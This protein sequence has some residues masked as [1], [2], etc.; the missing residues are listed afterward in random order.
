MA[1][2]NPVTENR[3]EPRPVSR[4]PY[5]AANF[6]AGQIVARGVEQVGEA[7]RE[8]A[9]A[10]HQ[11]NIQHAEAAA[12]QA[13]SEALVRVG[14]VRSQVETTSGLGAETR[15]QEGE[16]EIEQIGR[17]IEQSLGDP[18]ARRMFNDSFRSAT[19]SDRLRM[20]EHANRQIRVAEDAADEA[21]VDLS[22]TRMV[23]MRDDPAL[24]ARELQTMDAAIEHRF[25]GMPP[26][27][28]ELAKIRAHSNAHRATALAILSADE[29]GAGIEAMAYVREHA[30]EIVPEQELNLFQTIQPQLDNDVVS[31][32]LGETMATVARGETSAE[33]IAPDETSS[34][35][36]HEI[37]GTEYS[38][39]GDARRV[40]NQDVPAHQRRGRTAQDF[41]APQGTP[42]RPP[43]AGVVSSAPQT[44]QGANGYMIRVRHPN[45]LETTYLH[46]NGPSPLRE[47]DEVTA[48]TVLGG[49]GSTGHSTGPHVDFSVRN[50]STGAVVDPRSVT[51]SS[52]EL[53]LYQ[54][55]R[56]DLAAQYRAA[57]EVARRMGLNSR[58]YD[59]LLER[60]DRNAAREDRLEARRQ[61]ELDRQ[62]MVRIA[63]LD[64]NLTSISQVPS[65]GQLSPQ[66][67]M[68]IQDQ[69]RQ[70]TR[71]N[72][73]DANSDRYLDILDLAY[74]TT[75][76]QAAFMAINPRAE[77]V[78]RGE[79]AEIIR[80]QGAIRDSTERSLEDSRVAADY[81]RIDTAIRRS[82]TSGRPADINV[83]RGAGDTDRQRFNQL[84]EAV[85]IRVEREQR[86]KGG[87]LS[88]AEL[89]GAVNAEL[90][91]VTVRN[92]RGQP[93]G[94]A[95]QYRAGEIA[96]RAG[97]GGRMT[98]EVPM[99]D[100]RRI[101]SM[102]QDRGIPNP[103]Q[104]QIAYYYRRSLRGN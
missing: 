34:A 44:Q 48:Q 84:R 36:V 32:A 96:S 26:E 19:A 102:L 78:T 103:T 98:I 42:I 54:P 21:T 37:P 29:S 45:G 89:Q 87:P 14:E 66:L 59:Q 15:R 31:A 86:H 77:P 64:T 76:Q 61:A 3:V 39:V 73:P 1:I 17:E 69:I 16:R 33:P 49:V 95:P 60:I 92:D 65:Y 13:R 99:A 18:L 20:R 11:R 94:T 24:V 97:P 88:D 10:E 63:E 85:R 100:Q 4:Q 74:G 51:W 5:E 53:P 43:T 75:E 47:G 6:N 38:P 22:I 93:L 68:S 80:R 30:A 12:R 55:Q 67:Q 56:N 79:Q 23:D 35:P 62:A 8:F 71:I 91:E 7:G 72:E 70:N 41:A 90:L 52:E 46:M 81:G 83:G 9:P 101:I 104:E 25:R 28:I 50:S 57:N 40:P 2:V 82:M 27:A 58:Q